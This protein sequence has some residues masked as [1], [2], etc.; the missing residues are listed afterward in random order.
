MVSHDFALI[1]CGRSGK[2]RWSAAVSHQSLQTETL[3]CSEEG[4]VLGRGGLPGRCGLAQEEEGDQTSH[5]FFIRAVKLIY[6]L[7]PFSTRGRQWW[8]LKC[9][10]LTDLSAFF[11]ASWACCRFLLQRADKEGHIRCDTWA[12]SRHMPGTSWSALS[13]P[14]WPSVWLK[15]LPVFLTEAAWAQEFAKK[16]FFKFHTSRE[17]VL[18]LSFQLSLVGPEPWVRHLLAATGEASPPADALPAGEAAPADG[19]ALGASLGL[20]VPP[21]HAA[22]ELLQGTTQWHDG[23]HHRGLICANVWG[24]SRALLHHRTRH[25]F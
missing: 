13:K 8:L 24:R 20:R 22:G 9:V 7:A 10:F 18:P 2:S 17:E 6:L 14:V 11:L 12:S 15:A 23:I 21:G 16:N 3:E 5:F 4:I 1:S 19:L 25:S